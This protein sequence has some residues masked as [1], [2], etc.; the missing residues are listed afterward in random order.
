MKFI[1]KAVP[2]YA[3]GLEAKFCAVGPDEAYNVTILPSGEI[4][5][6]EIVFD[7]GADDWENGETIT[8]AEAFAFAVKYGL[9]EEVK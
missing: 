6:Q 2:D 3:I 9:I 1:I 4:V 5:A 8:G 7:D